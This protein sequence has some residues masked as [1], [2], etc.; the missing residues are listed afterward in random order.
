M[1]RSVG[2]LQEWSSVSDFRNEQFRKGLLQKPPIEEGRKEVPAGLEVHQGESYH[3]VPRC[4]LNKIKNY[5][6]AHC[7]LYIVHFSVPSFAIP[8]CCGAETLPQ[9]GGDDPR[10]IQKTPAQN[11]NRIPTLALWISWQQQANLICN[12]PWGGDGSRKSGHQKT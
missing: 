7:T 1:G 5:S 6:I 11:P 10:Q 9:G 8:G 3:V 4:T 12:I 2:Q